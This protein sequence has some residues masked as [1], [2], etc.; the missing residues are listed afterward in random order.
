[1]KQQQGADV[2]TVNL[3]WPDRALHPNSRSHW[4][5]KADATKRARSDAAVAALAAG[6]RKMS[7]SRLSV[8]AIFCP[9]DNRRRD[10]DGCLSALKASFDGIADVTGV[11]DHTWDIA[12]RRSDPVKG[13][14]V[15]IEIRGIE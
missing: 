10:T 4:A 1:M 14:N 15:L 2:V 5:I 6:L 12:I 3:P 11:D 7:V 13:G 8:T 9:P